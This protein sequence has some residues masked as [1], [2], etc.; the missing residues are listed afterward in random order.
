MNDNDIVVESVLRNVHHPPND[1]E[2][3]ND[4]TVSF[5]IAYSVFQVSLNFVGKIECDDS[6]INDSSKIAWFCGQK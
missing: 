5:D 2:V 3:E 1:T 6:R 4:E